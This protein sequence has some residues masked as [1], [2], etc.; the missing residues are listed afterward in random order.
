MNYIDTFIVMAVGIFL[1]FVA[2]HQFFSND[3]C[4][5]CKSRKSC[6]NVK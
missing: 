6:K 2:S 4:K 5:D 3:K 1:V